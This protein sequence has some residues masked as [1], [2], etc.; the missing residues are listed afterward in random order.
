MAIDQRQR[1][2]RLYQQHAKALVAFAASIVGP[3]D[4]ED[5]VASVA[6][7]IFSSPD[8]DRANNEQAYLY[9]A[10]RNAARSHLRSQ[11]RRWRREQRTAL[12]RAQSTDWSAPGPDLSLALDVLSP[13]QR[14]VVH[15]TYWEELTGAEVAERLGMSEGSVRKHLARAKDT[16]RGLIN[17]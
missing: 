17:D 16:L 8:L 7:R 6:G 3:S 9:Q 5:V 1:A 2:E 12:D 10:V 4:A 11:G 14:S 15:L 13:N